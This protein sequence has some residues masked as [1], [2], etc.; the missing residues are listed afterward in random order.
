LHRVLR[1]GRSVAATR[2]RVGGH[3]NDDHD[4]TPDYHDHDYS[5]PDY[6]DDV[7]HNLDDDHV[8]DTTSTNVD[9]DLNHD[10]NDDIDHHVD[11][12][13]DDEHHLDD[14][15]ALPALRRNGVLW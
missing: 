13:L 7:N 12:D 2:L 9:D 5:A 8:N 1:S 15:R 10:L 14:A 4:I 11:H 3:P 6:L